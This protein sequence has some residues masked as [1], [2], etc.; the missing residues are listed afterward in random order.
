MRLVRLLALAVV[1]G[2]AAAPWYLLTVQFSEL[3]GTL[4]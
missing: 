4:P 1:I 2:I 3:S